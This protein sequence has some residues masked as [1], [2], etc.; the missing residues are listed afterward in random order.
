MEW[1]RLPQPHELEQ[2]YV[3]ARTCRR[4]EQGLGLDIDGQR[5]YPK[6]NITQEKRAGEETTATCRPDGTHPPERLESN[7]WTHKT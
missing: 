3:T 5:V 7:D 6:R 4:V 1:R 2:L